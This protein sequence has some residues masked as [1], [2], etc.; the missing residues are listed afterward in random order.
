MESI[1]TEEDGW[2]HRPERLDFLEGIDLRGTKFLPRTGRSRRSGRF[3]YD[4]PLP[5]SLPCLGVLRRNIAR[6][7]SSIGLAVSWL[8]LP[9]ADGRLA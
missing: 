4:H 9:I 3:A 7:R 6:H 8:R 2:R 1:A 5:V